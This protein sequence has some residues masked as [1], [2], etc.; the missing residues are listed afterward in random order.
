MLIE[1]LI[2][3]GS[4]LEAWRRKSAMIC[5]RSANVLSGVGHICPPR[6]DRPPCVDHT[7]IGTGSQK[8]IGTITLASAND[9]YRPG[10]SVPL[11]RRMA[12]IGATTA[13]RTLG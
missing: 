5:W 8:L 9:G 2:A 13:P 11:I 6:R 3:L 7:V 4:A 1:G 10:P 12:G